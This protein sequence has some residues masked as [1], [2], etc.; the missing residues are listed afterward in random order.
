METV[1]T[2]LKRN[3]LDEV[4]RMWEMVIWKTQIEC[5]A[6]ENWC[7]ANKNQI[8]ARI[9]AINIPTFTAVRGISGT[10][11]NTLMLEEE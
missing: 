8:I 1:Y 11:R 3:Y 5:M 9:S 7:D 2:E 4:L 6:L 10:Y